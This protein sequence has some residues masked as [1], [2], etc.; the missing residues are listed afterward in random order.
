MNLAGTEQKQLTAPG[1]VDSVL[2]VSNDG[3]YIVFH[4]NRN[5]GFDIWRMNIDGGNPVQLT[6]GRQN[7]QPFVSTDNVYVYYKSWENGAG[8][9]RRVSID[10][11]KPEIINDKETKQ[12]N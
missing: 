4:S 2:N 8:E 12:E 9:L 6:F 5:G 3:R 1:S 7:Y 10:G 11:G